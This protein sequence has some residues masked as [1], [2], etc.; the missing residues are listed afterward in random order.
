[1][2][3]EDDLEI[4]KEIQDFEGFYEISNF[5]RVR[6][7]D[8]VIDSGQG[9]CANLKGK[10]LKANN[11]GAL[12]NYPSVQL[13]MGGR[14][15]NHKIHRL[16]AEAFIPNPDD[17]PEVNHK[18][19]NT[20]NN[21]ASNLEWVTASENVTHALGSGL[22]VRGIGLE[23]KNT[24]Y[25]VEVYKDSKY[26]TTL[27]GTKSMIEYGLL[28]SKVWLCVNGKRKTHK[29]FSFKKKTI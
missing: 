9:W 1:M 10:V 18:D 15:K 8:R 28:P 17:K 25:A 2:A 11:T 27:I 16:V 26:I 3:E 5:G 22:L 4:W 6:S 24:K 29:G 14:K 20:Q 19:G 12:R 13:N 21:H 23:C 7:V